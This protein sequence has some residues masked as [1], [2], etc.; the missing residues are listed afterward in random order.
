VPTGGTVFWVEP[1][2]AWKIVATPDFDGDGKA[3]ILW[4]NSVTG[5]VYGMQMSGAIVL[6]ASNFYTDPNIHWSIVSVGD[7]AGSGKR[8]Q[9]LWRNDQT[10][11]VF[12]MTVT[13][14]AGTFGQTGQVIYSEPGAWKI[15]L[16]RASSGDEDGHLAQ[17]RDRPRLPDVD[18]RPDDQQRRAG[19]RRGEPQLE[20]RLRRRLQRRREVGHPLPQLRNRAGLPAADERLLGHGRRSR[21]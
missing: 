16:A 1:N 7:F 15:R 2:P 17:R 9:L 5:Q 10:G 11:Q 13:L 21:L 12:L 20:D 18:E 8:N 14:S 3:D 4:R 6:A 19:V